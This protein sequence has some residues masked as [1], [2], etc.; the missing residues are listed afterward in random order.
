METTW[1]YVLRDSSDA[2]RYVG[3]TAQPLVRRHHWQK[4]RPG[5]RFELSHEVPRGQGVRAEKELIRA[6][7]AKGFALVNMNAGGAGDGLGHPSRG[8]GGPPSA[9]A[10]IKISAT[11]MGNQNAKGNV[12]SKESKAKMSAAMMGNRS[13]KEQILTGD[14]K[15]R[16]ST[17]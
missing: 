12:H 15:A 2:I 6:L 13:R 11:L 9:E 16:I 3:K 17:A 4:E 1:I 7:R 8:G 14:H 10:R 5:W